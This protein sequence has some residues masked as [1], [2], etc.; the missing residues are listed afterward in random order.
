LKEAR[1]GQAQAWSAVMI[2]N[3]QSSIISHG[4]WHCS[5]LQES[6][7]QLVAKTLGHVFFTTDV[8]HVPGS[9]SLV[10]S[11]KSLDYHTDHH[12]ADLILWHCKQQCSIG[13]ETL[14]MDGGAIINKLDANEVT[15]LKSIRLR[16]HKVLDDDPGEYPM[17]SFGDGL[18]KLY[19]SFWMIRDNATRG[20]MRA[21][22]AFMDQVKETKPLSFHLQPGDVLIVDNNRM[23]HGRNAI[24]GDKQR[25]LRRLWISRQPINQPRR[26]P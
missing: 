2:G 5:G 3:I 21:I 11:D 9:K 18:M 14:I 23:L 25:L 20:Q 7:A 17:V 8:T 4:F 13:G 19:Y 6:D 1:D 24:R 26:C 16:E 22:R 12:R 10:T 15:H